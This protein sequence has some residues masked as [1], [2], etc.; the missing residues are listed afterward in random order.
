[1]PTYER[2]TGGEVFVNPAHV[3]LA[4][5]DEVIGQ[6]R[7]LLSNVVLGISPAG[8]VLSPVFVTVKVP[9]TNVR[10]DLSAWEKAQRRG[11]LSVVA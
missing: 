8:A 3:T 6:T 7:L 1:M 11:G 5:P 2:T 4:E 9:W 10:A